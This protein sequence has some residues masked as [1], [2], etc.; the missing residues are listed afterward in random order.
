VR[1]LT[2]SQALL[3]A[4]TEKFGPFIAVSRERGR[5]GTE[6]SQRLAEKLGWQLFHVRTEELCAY[7]VIINTAY[8]HV[9]TATDL[10][11][12]LAEAKLK[13]LGLWNGG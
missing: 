10:V 5:G 7:D 6:I 11:I 13:A 2:A 1:N 9:E 3:R 12:R 4:H 8:L